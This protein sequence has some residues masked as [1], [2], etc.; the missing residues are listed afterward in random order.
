M[1]RRFT[2]LEHGVLLSSLI[3]VSKVFVKLA[4][5]LNIQTVKPFTETLVPVHVLI[6]FINTPCLYLVY[7]NFKISPVEPPFYFNYIKRS[8]KS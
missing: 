1:R 4:A 2:K 7:D 8:S 5:Y 3:K 6:N